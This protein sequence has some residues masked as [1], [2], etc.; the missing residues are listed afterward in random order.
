[1]TGTIPN[2]LT[3]RLRRWGLLLRDGKFECGDKKRSISITLEKGTL[4]ISYEMED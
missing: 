3:R 4:Y 2:F 1:M